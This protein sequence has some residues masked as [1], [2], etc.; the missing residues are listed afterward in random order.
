VDNANALPTV[1]QENRSRRSGQVNSLSTSPPFRCENKR[2][3]S[4]YS[5]TISDIQ[6]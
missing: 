2:C 6:K 1:P 3:L 4:K 5:I